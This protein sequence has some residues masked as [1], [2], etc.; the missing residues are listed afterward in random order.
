MH[1]L[2]TALR[3]QRHMIAE[4][5]AAYTPALVVLDGVEAFTDRGP[6]DGRRVWSEA[7]LAGTDR[8]AIDA[9]GVA[10]LRH[11]GTTKKVGRG[12]VFQQ[13]QLARAVELGL[14]VDS[15]D[16][17]ELVTDDEPSA[18]YAELLRGILLQE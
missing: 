17:I 2:H 4:V 18:A 12:P 10:L 6:E 1:E 15:P 8:V 14:G 16:K 7:I 13:E 5:N 3:H 11:F 9:V